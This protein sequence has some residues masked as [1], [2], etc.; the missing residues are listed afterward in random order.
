M[1]LMSALAKGCAFGHEGVVGEV[2]AETKTHN[3]AV[4]IGF[5]VDH[6]YAL[7]KS[8]NFFL[9]SPERISVRKSS[10]SINTSICFCTVLFYLVLRACESR[11]P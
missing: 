5:A 9:L 2:G 8:R 4:E 6:A 11:M 1:R 10:F 3:E 7:Q